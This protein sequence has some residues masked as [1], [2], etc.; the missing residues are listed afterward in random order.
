MIWIFSKFYSELQVFRDCVKTAAD[1][2]YLSFRCNQ[3]TIRQLQFCPLED[4]LGI[5]AERGFSSILVPGSFY[6]LK[7]EVKIWARFDEI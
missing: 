5:G 6:N 3:S 4:V 2:P 1:R 7:I